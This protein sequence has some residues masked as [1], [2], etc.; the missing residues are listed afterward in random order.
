MHDIM[1]TLQFVFVAELWKWPMQE[2]SMNFI[3][4]NI[5][6]PSFFFKQV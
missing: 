4:N 6:L 2:L 3:F 1:F 5:F